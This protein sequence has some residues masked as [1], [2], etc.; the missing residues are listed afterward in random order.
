MAALA[1]RRRDIVFAGLAALALAGA[2]FSA[3]Q[4]RS[5]SVAAPVLERGLEWVWVTGRVLEIEARQSGQRLVLGEVSVSRLD[6][7]RTPARVRIT[8]RIG[9]SGVRPGD[10]IRVRADLMPPP[11]PAA[12]G[13]FDF[14]RMAWFERLGAVGFTRSRAQIEPAASRPCGN[15]PA[16]ASARRCRAIPAPSPPP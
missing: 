10:V 16:F 14:A 7:A 11:A 3:A 12:P 2:G 15:R 4:W 1:A 9:D 6:P 8:D 5:A 13:A